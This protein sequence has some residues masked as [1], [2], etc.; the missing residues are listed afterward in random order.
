MGNY[1]IT[2]CTPVGGGAPTPEIFALDLTVTGGTSY[3]PS[4][5]VTNNASSTITVCCTN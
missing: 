3:T 5:A 4:G 2:P 1:Q